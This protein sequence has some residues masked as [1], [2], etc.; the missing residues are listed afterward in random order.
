MP[1]A[2]EKVA[3]ELLGVPIDSTPQAFRAAFLTRLDR[4]GFVPPET[5]CA[6]LAGSGKPVSSSGLRFASTALSDARHAA[7]GKD[8]ELFRSAFWT[9]ECS[10]RSNQ[11]QALYEQCGQDNWL[12]RNLLALRPGLLTRAS[13]FGLMTGMQASIAEMI[14]DSFPLRAVERANRRNSWIASLDGQKAWGQQAC[15]FRQAHPKLAALDPEL[16]ERLEMLSAP[17]PPAV[18]WFEPNVPR[19]NNRRFPVIAV[20]VVL[21]AVFIALVARPRSHPQNGHSSQPAVTSG[22]PQ[23]DNLSASQKAVVDSLMSTRVAKL[24]AC[25]PDYGTRIVNEGTLAPELAPMP[26]LA[27]SFQPGDRP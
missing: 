10:A 5:W 3:A 7:L 24:P 23:Y 20:V 13:A 11:W 1:A 15:F 21:V 4:V 9:L 2:I 16:L 17:P 18:R 12:R 22:V 6:G 25:I 19:T 27:A 14:R 8:I 26:R